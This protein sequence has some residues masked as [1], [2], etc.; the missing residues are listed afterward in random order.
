MI[1]VEY[2]LFKNTNARRETFASIMK[3]ILM[4]GI[5]MMIIIIRIMMIIIISIVIVIMI[6]V[7]TSNKNSYFIQFP[8]HCSS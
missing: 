4:V 2:I 1:S 3:L 7:I 8:L 6:M 5:I